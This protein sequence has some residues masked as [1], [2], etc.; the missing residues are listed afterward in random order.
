MMTAY[1]CR[2]RDKNNN[3]PH[4]GALSLRSAWNEH[5]LPLSPC[6]SHRRAVRRAGGRQRPQRTEDRE[7][8]SANRLRDKD[9]APGKDRGTRVAAERSMT[10]AAEHVLILQK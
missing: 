6:N 8:R 1:L 7:V 4:R 2:D 5:A 9:A 3:T 10:E